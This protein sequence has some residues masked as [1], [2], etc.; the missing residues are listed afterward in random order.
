MGNER[1]AMGK[2]PVFAKMKRLN[3]IPGM[4]ALLPTLILMVLLSLTT[5][6]FLSSDNIMNIL[7]Q[8]AVYAIIATGMTFVTITAGVDLSVG[9]TLALCCVVCCNVLNTTGNLV[10]AI[11]ASVI[12]GAAIGVFNGLIIAYIGVP[13]FIMTLGSMYIVRGLTLFVT[14][15][16]QVS[17]S[18]YD[19]FR[20]IG[21]GSVVGIPFPVFVFLAV[22]AAGAFFL[23][24]TSTGR[25][26]F[27]VGSNRDAAVLSGVKV[28]KILVLVYTVSG[29]CVGI[30]SVVYLARLTAAQPT[31]GQAYEMEAIAA[32]VVGGT[33]QAGGEGGVIGSLIGAVLIAVIRNGLVL[34]GVGSYFTN[35]VVGFIIVIAVALDVTRRRLAKNK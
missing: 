19:T 7:R 13:P 24:Y 29:I 21:Q 2:C 6:T 31:A 5:D 20:F 1:T 15:S 14:N 34:L 18:G 12:T 25:Q 28:E 22:G 32:T 33:S 17:F 16:K 35:I 26:I 8:A 3:N 9:S 30:A 10:L 27:A 23:T 4:S 11:L